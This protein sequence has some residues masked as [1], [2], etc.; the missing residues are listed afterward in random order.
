MLPGVVSEKGQ[1]EIEPFY[2]LPFFPLNERRGVG[3][4][5]KVG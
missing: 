3:G 4:G 1:R 5:K 2:F